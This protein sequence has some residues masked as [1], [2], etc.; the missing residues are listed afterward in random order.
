MNSKLINQFL[1]SMDIIADEKIK[2]LNNNTVV[3]AT[4]VEKIENSNKYV[5]EAA[6][7][8]FS[9]V[10][11]E[12]YKV[13]D[14]IRVLRSTTGNTI[15]GFAEYQ[16]APADV[17]FDNA[18]SEYLKLSANA[19]ISDNEGGWSVDNSALVNATALYLE[20]DFTVTGVDLKSDNINYNIIFT[21]T[22]TTGAEHSLTF[23]IDDVVG[24]PFAL[25]QSTQKKR[26]ELDYFLKEITEI[27]I[28]KTDCTFNV[29][30]LA[31]YSSSN[32][33]INDGIY[34]YQN[35]D[36]QSN[37]VVA[38]NQQKQPI[39]IENNGA[40]LSAVLYKNGK[41]IK[42][43]DCTVAWFR[44][45]YDSNLTAVP[46]L[47][48]TQIGTENTLELTP[49]YASNEIITCTIGLEGKVYTAK[50]QTY[51]GNYVEPKMTYEYSD[52]NVIFKANIQKVEDAT[53]TY[54]WY[55]Y[56]N[57]DKSWELIKEQN[58]EKYTTQY[59]TQKI[60]CIAC[61]DKYI[62]ADI[63]QEIG[64]PEGGAI[65]GNFRLEGVTT[66][67]Y[68]EGGAR[69]T[70]N[71]PIYFSWWN[72]ATESWV[73]LT[74]DINGVTFP[75]GSGI[76][77]KIDED[78]TY[79][80]YDAP[81]SW[82]GVTKLSNRNLTIQYN[83][84]Q[85]TFTFDF[86][87]QGMA[88]TNGTQYRAEICTID[89][90]DTWADYQEYIQLKLGD[91]VT[92]GA[93]LV[94][95]ETSA[96]VTV[97]S[98]TFSIWETSNSVGTDIILSSNSNPCTITANSVF[99]ENNS[100]CNIVRAEL[101][102]DGKK[103]YAFLPIVVY[104][105]G[106][107]IK[108]KSVR[109]GFTNVLYSSSGTN[110]SWNDC[111]FEFNKEL[112]ELSSNITDTLSIIG[113]GQNWKCNP[114]MAMPSSQ[115]AKCISLTGKVGSEKVIHIPFLF[116]LNTYE[117]AFINGWDGS[118]FYEQDGKIAAIQGAFGEKN[119]DN[120]FTGVILG[121]EGL[122]A[123]KDGLQTVKISSTDGS[124]TFDGNVI[125][126]GRFIL[127]D[128]EN[129]ESGDAYIMRAY[130]E[131]NNEPYI[132]IDNATVGAW[133]L[134]NDVFSYDNQ[135]GDIKDK[136]VLTGEKFELIRDS[137]SR[138]GQEVVLTAQ[139]EETE[140]EYTSTVSC[141]Y[142][143]K[144]LD[145]TFPIDTMPTSYLGRSF[146]QTVSY[147]ATYSWS[148]SNPDQPS[149]SNN[150][151]L[152]LTKSNT[153]STVDESFKYSFPTL[154]EWTI[155]A[156]ERVRFNNLDNTKFSYT[157]TDIFYETDDKS[158]SYSKDWG[159][160]RP[161]AQWNDWS[162][163]LSGAGINE[164]RRNAGYNYQ[165][166]IG[167]S[168]NSNN[169]TIRYILNT[170]NYILSADQDV[171]F[172]PNLPG[173]AVGFYIEDSRPELN[174]E[175]VIFADDMSVTLLKSKVDH[176]LYTQTITLP[177]KCEITCDI[178]KFPYTIYKATDNTLKT[179]QKTAFSRNG[180]DLSLVV[181]D[182]EEVGL[183][184]I[185]LGNITSQNICGR[186]L[187]GTIPLGDSFTT[188]GSTKLGMTVNSALFIR[189]DIVPYHDDDEDKKPQGGHFSI[190]HSGRTF[191]N[192]WV[193]N[194]RT[195]IT[196]TTSGTASQSDARVKTDVSALSEQYELLF[197]NLKPVRF[198][199]I[200][201]TSNRLHTG[202]IAQEVVESLNQA[203]LDTLQFAGVVLDNQNA[204]DECWYLRYNEFVALN[205]WQIQ[206]LK[207]RIAE[208][209]NAIRSLTQRL[210]ALENK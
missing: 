8:R 95:I 112:N 203:G 65:Q 185:A 155:N 73:E 71:A 46:P 138:V 117:N 108:D 44:Q 61:T 206:R 17:L 15:L 124:A 135:V 47:G 75:L 194:A 163:K 119:T 34:I 74:P 115:Y 159:Y 177:T 116:T 145:T 152:S 21:V 7:A 167:K 150:Q 210:E 1:D 193:N 129:P 178:E 101:Q 174:D 153:F 77:I 180:F 50:V 33:T 103:Y 23:G 196:Y 63:E 83:N 22:D 43:D 192:L 120:T 25:A 89:N 81:Q 133:Q 171:E 36:K 56:D 87:K 164:N 184:N 105:E 154:E 146:S 110:P 54:Y 91:T 16:S 148:I 78:K 39:Q 143:S 202:F 208:Q 38:A 166:G 88:G 142:A 84:E 85:A 188:S 93:R 165:I 28:D 189:D 113:S 156:Y 130:N 62:I 70:A 100:T 41:Q 48:L 49:V 132:K 37:L 126:R 122:I 92:V 9:V 13:G 109:R 79:Y 168:E 140:S 64:R 195:D 201:G 131:K 107:N 94:N 176:V 187:Y 90:T 40:T 72:A 114:P 14:R 191:H 137:D 186:A 179:L 157:Y 102:Y 60:R 58:T 11:A 162:T 169:L 175:H 158:F 3:E 32:E 76:S 170:P 59:T 98:V 182:K 205:T 67:T 45:K 125:T 134:N 111:T 104:V 55:Q 97:S 147:T 128:K 80:Y 121:Q 30:N 66:F 19:A 199:Y 209:D 161:L 204:E 2:R 69:V 106:Y 141:S 200:N 151:K 10:G 4:I 86:I 136:T 190:G 123:Q 53:V 197:E 160:K 24:N 118:S 6:G 31:I 99:N 57:T 18:E 198:K 26:I 35:I 96:E 52:N 29:E 5:A 173:L 144:V 181:Q 68:S 183:T 127:G 27:K 42:V 207:A 12:T 20:A 172:N 149:E 51:I 82:L 139:V